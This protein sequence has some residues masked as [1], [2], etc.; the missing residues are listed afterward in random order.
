MQLKSSLQHI[1]NCSA[2]GKLKENTTIAV[3]QLLPMQY[4]LRF[5]SFLSSLSINWQ[6]EQYICS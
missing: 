4:I 1:P 2:N 3:T 6:N 5:F